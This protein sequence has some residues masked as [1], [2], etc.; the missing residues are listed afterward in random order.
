[1][2]TC[3]AVR[4]LPTA[5]LSPGDLDRLR[6]FLDAAYDGE[7]GDDDWSHALGG[8][9]VLAPWTASRPGTRRSSSGS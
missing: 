3:P 6:A 1:V 5:D 8:V 7:F 2:S 4:S 9:H